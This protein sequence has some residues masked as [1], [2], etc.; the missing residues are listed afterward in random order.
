M[1]KAGYVQGDMNPKVDDY[2]M[3]MKDFAEHDFSKTTQYVERQD[4]Q[5]AQNKKQISKQ[6]FKGRYS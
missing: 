1:S 5:Q 4:K 3:P 6:D 2:Q